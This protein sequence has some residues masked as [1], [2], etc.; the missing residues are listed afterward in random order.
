MNSLTPER[1][2]EIESFVEQFASLKAEASDKYHSAVVRLDHI[3]ALAQ[4][5]RAL[6]QLIMETCAGCQ[7]KG[8]CGFGR[9]GFGPWH[10]EFHAAA[11]EIL[12]ALE[13]LRKIAAS[14]K[15]CPRTGAEVAEAR[16]DLKA[17]NA[18]LRAEL[19][20]LRGDRERLDWLIKNRHTPRAA[21]DAARSV[22]ATE[23]QE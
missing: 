8:L 13:P 6:T 15:D 19:E 18:S 1:L 11:T 3:I 5:Y 14:W 7:G 16:I 21:I 23:K 17:E 20:S 9:P 2:A 22:S 12:A 4:A 10:T